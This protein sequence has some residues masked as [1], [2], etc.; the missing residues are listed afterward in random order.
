[1]P[2]L[3]RPSSRE[4]LKSTAAVAG[5][6]GGQPLCQFAATTVGIGAKV[7]GA[8]QGGE[9]VMP[10]HFGRGERCQTCAKG[11]ERG[12]AA[13]AGAAPLERFSLETE[14]DIGNFLR[15]PNCFPD[16]FTTAAQT[17]RDRITAHGADDAGVKAWLA[18][19]DAV[20]AN[21]AKDV[22]LPPL[23]ANAPDW[24]KVDRTYQEG[25]AELY[26]RH[27][28]EAVRRFTAIDEEAGSPW[29]RLGP[30]LAAR[31]A[32]HGVRAAP[33]DAAAIAE[34]RQSS[35]A[36]VR[37]PSQHGSSSATPASA[38]TGR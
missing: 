1:M 38:P 34:A 6:P 26:R 23:G 32:V 25:A 15:V 37:A 17:L 21:C 22:G 33:T 30:Y 12:P 16:A 14:R 10:A 8:G 19:Q 20:F 11:V 35:E 4:S 3:A 9:L 29:H 5:R 28:A 27:F 31:A 36:A 7:E 13:C 2:S 18:T 24:L